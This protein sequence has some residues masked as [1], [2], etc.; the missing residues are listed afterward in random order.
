VTSFAEH[1]VE[2]YMNELEAKDEV[3]QLHSEIER[4]RDW[5]QVTLDHGGNT[6]NVEDIEEGIRDLRYMAWFAPDAVAIT[7]IIDYPNYR[8]FHG[9]LGGGNK[10]TLNDMLPSMEGY[11]RALGCKRMSACGRV[12]WGREWRKFGFKSTLTTVIKELGTMPEG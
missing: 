7:E 11:A 5:L 12:G 6:H 8:V 9:F 2:E 1:V 3:D 4:C 10:E